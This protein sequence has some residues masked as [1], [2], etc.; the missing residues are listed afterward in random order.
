[1]SLFEKTKAKDIIS[2]KDRINDIVSTTISDMA[3][4]VG[5]TL[6][7]GGRGV[8]I[9]RDGLSPTLTQDGVTV[10]KSLGVS[11]AEAN[12]VIE[13]AKEICL[14][15]AKEAGDGTTTAI[16]LADAVVKYGQKFIT[17]NPRYN[18]QK[19]VRELQ[20]AYEEI[21]IPYLAD[22]AIK[23]EDEEQLESVATIS[24][25]G[26]INI[27]KAVVEAVMAAGDDGTVLIEEGEGDIM[28]VETQDGLLVTAGLRE[29]GR[30]GPV[31]INDNTNQQCKMDQ[32][33]VLCY[34]GDMVDLQAAGY[35]QD[36]I[37]GTELVGKPVLIFAHDFSDVVLDKIAKNVKAG[38][39]IL[40][41]KSPRSGLP[42]SRSMFL[43]D[44]AAYTGARV[45]DAGDI[46]ECD[47]T[48]LGLFV[49]AKS[50]MFE[51]FIIGSPNQEDIDKR[52]GELKAIAKASAS[53]FDKMHIRAAIGKLIGGVS[54][55]W[56]GGASEL[57]IREKKH[58]VED[59]VESVRSAIAEG[60]I[61]G[62]CSVQLTLANIIE[63]SKSKKDSYQILVK[64]LRDPFK[65][66]LTNC[67]ESYDEI[68]PSI[69]KYVKVKGLP[70]KVFDANEH[71]IV[72][73]EKAG[74]IEPAK[75][76]R[77]TIRNALSVSSLLIT[78]GGIVCVPRD[79][80]LE[81]QMAIADKAFKD[82]MAG[83]GMGA[84]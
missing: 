72:N 46:Q 12:I 5:S 6:G 60:I 52:V 11:S 23:V 31:F 54:T 83:G 38:L 7:P 74:I 8:L 2:D 80:N 75:V 58:R 19:V 53:E 9:E 82:M 45:Y 73:A 69:E 44:V 34:D 14:N 50:N 40:P 43:K 56:V 33:I 29:L 15:T 71:K 25:N 64:A 70:K 59:A 47:H 42:N 78:L 62:G 22:N 79:A 13:A 16:I 49:G 27:A 81:N 10:A 61:P 36:A 63:N 21:V 39:N 37:E 30:I 66:L 17:D 84:N 76:C 51:T 48:E 41:I 65:L 68:W 67:G 32:G 3:K 77:V 26:D 24:A 55:I 20:K 1:M 35:L 4:I 28:R 18:P 57:E